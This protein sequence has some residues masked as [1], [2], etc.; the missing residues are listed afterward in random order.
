MIQFHCPFKQGGGPYTKVSFKQR[1]T[2]VLLRALGHW[3]TN[4]G[5]CQYLIFN[6]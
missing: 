6:K 5:T 1:L 4:Q 3:E 2:V